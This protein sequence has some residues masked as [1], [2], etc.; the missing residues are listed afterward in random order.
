MWFAAGVACCYMFVVGPSDVVP[1]ISATAQPAAPRPAAVA[2]ATGHAVAVVASKG[3]GHDKTKCLEQGE[4]DRD[5]CGFEKDIAC[6]D[7]YV[8]VL[9]GTSCWGRNRDYRCMAP[10]AG[11]SPGEA[12]AS[13]VGRH[14]ALHTE[15]KAL[16]DDVR[17][18][19]RARAARSP[20][21]HPPSVFCLGSFW[22]GLRCMAPDGSL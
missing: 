21:P 22:G 15:V 19:E 2:L 4:R 5:C 13:L 9:A 16:E 18:R 20:P 14:P 17:R 8:L 12:E 7:G 6:A 10:A 3:A 1:S 11:D